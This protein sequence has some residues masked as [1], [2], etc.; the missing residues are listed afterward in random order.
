MGSSCMLR[1]WIGEQAEA[2]VW[3]REAGAETWEL[4]AGGHNVPTKAGLAQLQALAWGDSSVM[5]GWL[6]V[7]S[8]D[9]A[10]NENQTAL[11]SE[12]SQGRKAFTGHT[13]TEKQTNIQVYFAP[14]EAVGTIKEWGIFNASSGGVMLSRGIVEPSKAKSDTQE[15]IFEV[16]LSLDAA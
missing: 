7:G 14:H 12:I 5:F 1:E 9:T 3:M 15:M 16:V 2:R 6:A 13:V 8:D 10:A 11:V 4:V